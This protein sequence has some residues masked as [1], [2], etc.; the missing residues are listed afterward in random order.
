LWFLPQAGVAGK[1][2]R[3]ETVKSPWPEKRA[4]LTQIFP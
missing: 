4:V 2:F 1:E 3:L